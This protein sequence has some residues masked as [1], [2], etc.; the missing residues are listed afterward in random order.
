VGIHLEWGARERV[1]VLRR[2]QL[3]DRQGAAHS[4][5]GLAI[6]K[7]LIIRLDSTEFRRER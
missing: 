4:A 7:M 5:G 3:R 1:L 2:H 6:T